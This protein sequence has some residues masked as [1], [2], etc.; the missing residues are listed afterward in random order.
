MI[1]CQELELLIGPAH[2]LLGQGLIP[3]APIFWGRTSNIEDAVL[4]DETYVN[5]WARFSKWS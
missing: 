3:G 2:G 5:G 4:E 1:Q